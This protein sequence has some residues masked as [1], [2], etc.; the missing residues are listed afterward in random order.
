[1]NNAKKEYWCVIDEYGDSQ[2]IDNIEAFSSEAGYVTSGSLY[3]NSKKNIERLKNNKKNLLLLEIK[4]LNVNREIIKL[5][6]YRCVI[7]KIKDLKELNDITISSVHKGILRAMRDKK[8]H[9][10]TLITNEGIK[11]FKNK[12]EYDKSKNIDNDIENSD[13]IFNDTVVLTHKEI[14]G[15]KLNEFSTLITDMETKVNQ[16]TSF[17]TRHSCELN[18]EILMLPEKDVRYCPY[19]GAEIQYKNANFC[20][21]CRAKL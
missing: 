6:G 12:R 21:K 9:P 17:T 15:I 5:Q 7:F 11:T 2:I 10:V 16:Q 3:D 19:C 1:M 14:N 8:E 13:Y 18:P 4:T 20:T